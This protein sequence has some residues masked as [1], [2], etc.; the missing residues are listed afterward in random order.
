M[1]KR[2]IDVLGSV[3]GLL[4]LAPL[5][6][7]AAIAIK[8]DSPGP[9]F[10]RQVR[11]GRHGVEFRIHKLRTM[12]ELDAGEVGSAMQITVGDDPRITRVGAL[13]RR[14]KLDE[15]A[16]LIDVG[17]GHMSLVG[18][19]PEVPRYVAAYPQAMRDKLLGVRPGITDPASLAF[20]DESDR[21]TQAAD[22][23]REY[24][25]VV[26][27]AKLAISAKYIDEAN[28]LSDLRCIAATVRTLW[29][30]R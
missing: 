17:L 28:A 10:F 6:L 21:L 11:V 30:P 12:R 24:L 7:V 14:T 29:T 19:R 23:Q 4:L 15:L 2:L 22:P 9:V 8:L 20:R 25:E 13:L 3:C 27:P 1:T 5:L 26:M 18:P 16:Q